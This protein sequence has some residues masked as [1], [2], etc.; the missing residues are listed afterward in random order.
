MKRNMAHNQFLLLNDRRFLPLFITQFLGAFHD[1]LFKNAFVVI[2]L[3]GVASQASQKATLGID[4]KLL[5]T[6]AAGLFILPFILFSAI[7]GQLADKLP[8]DR[9]IRIVKIAEILIALA[10]A[11]SLLIGSVV[12]SFI[13][14][15]ALGAQSAFFGPC[16]FSILPQ[17]LQQNELIGGNALLNTGTFLA[18]LTGTIAGTVLI[19]LPYGSIIVSLSLITCACIGY[20]SSRHIPIAP[21]STPH[22]RVRYNIITQ[23][24]RILHD[25]LV[26]DRFIRR[27]ILGSAWFYAMGGMFT[28]QLAN[29]TEESL[30]GNAHVL[31]FLLVLFSIGI[32]MGGLLNNKLLKGRVEATFVPIAVFFISVFSV[33]LYFSSPAIGVHTGPLLSLSQFLENTAH[34]RVIFDISMIA[35]CGGLFIVPLKAIIQ[36]RTIVAERARI[37]AASSVMDA[38]FIISASI[39]SGACIIYGWKIVEIF[40]AFACINALVAVYLCLLL[41]PRILNKFKK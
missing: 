34:W 18:V 41:P 31:A 5:V 39:A 25:A 8:K 6:A 26:R 27:T 20:A 30:N 4:P 32:A 23:T 24:Y 1:N 12:M 19:T 33:D 9:I 37:V 29:F 36:D 16:K 22:F 11:F 17:H 28:A 10:G 3:F 21:S 15:F 40:L 14:L 35:I 13:V 2:L 38:V 7:A